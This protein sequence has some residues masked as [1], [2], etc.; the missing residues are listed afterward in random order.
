MACLALLVRDTPIGNACNGVAA[1]LDL[2]FSPKRI[3]AVGKKTAGQATAATEL[4]V[5]ANRP[6]TNEEGKAS[7]C[8]YEG[9]ALVVLRNYGRR[10]TRPLQRRLRQFQISPDAFTI[11][12]IVSEAQ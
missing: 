9:I 1:G 11:A 6:V 2:P 7:R 8:P 4:R 3:A 10:I 5:I 12:R